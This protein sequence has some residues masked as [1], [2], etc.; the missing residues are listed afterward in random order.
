MRLIVNLAIAIVIALAIGVSS[1]WMMIQ[2]GRLFGA[3]SADGWTAYPGEGTPDPDPYALAILARSGELPLGVGEGIAF[4]A[5]SDADGEPLDGRCTYTIT[6]ETPPAR[7]WTLVAY[8]TDGELMD[9]A[10][11]RPGFHSRE[12]LRASSGAFTI[13]ASQEVTAG[14]WLPIQ[15]VERFVFM[16]RLYDT[17]LTTGSQIASLIMPEIHKGACR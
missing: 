17:P 9:N 3:V 2:Q 15:P 14:N 1:A 8:G 4:T 16:L 10:S 12:I 6:G 11:Y 5:D 13:T 7:M